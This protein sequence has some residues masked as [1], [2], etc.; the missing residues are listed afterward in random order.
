MGFGVVAETQGRK[1]NS[2]VC[3]AWRK[4][5]EAMQLPDGVVQDVSQADA[6]VNLE[7]FSGLLLQGVGVLRRR[8][9][10]LNN[11]CSQRAYDVY[12]PHQTNVHHHF[13]VF[14][15]GVATNALCYTP[16]SHSVW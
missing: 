6:F 7:D 5:T 8:P 16:V 15:A 11:N 4:Y 2:V 9:A 12:G 10:S 1:V 3:G 14:W 13:I